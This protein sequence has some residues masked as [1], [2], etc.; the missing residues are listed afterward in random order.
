MSVM[1]VVAACRGRLDELKELHAKGGYSHDVVWDA[2]TAAAINNHASVVQWMNKTLEPE[3]GAWV[4]A[5]AAAAGAGHPGLTLKM[6]KGEQGES[7]DEDDTGDNDDW[8]GED[9]NVCALTWSEA[10]FAAVKRGHLSVCLALASVMPEEVVVG[11]GEALMLACQNDHVHIVEWLMSTFDL[12]RDDI[13][14]DALVA[15]AARGAARV[16]DWAL[17][18]SEF[19]CE[20]RG[21]DHG[22]FVCRRRPSVCV[23]AEVVLRAAA[24]HGHVAICDQIVRAFRFRHTE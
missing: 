19:G 6:L 15:A 4:N 8:R 20:R 10:L 3:W 21:A 17:T 22:L 24:A 18:S 9:V 16:M 1:F 11:E 2:L 7:D 13:L 5:T 12:Y 14:S 23:G